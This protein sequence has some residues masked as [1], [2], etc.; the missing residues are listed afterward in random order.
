MTATQLQTAAPTPRPAPRFPYLTNWRHA[1]PG[2]LYPSSVDRWGVQRDD[3]A[4]LLSRLVSLSPEGV[5]GYTLRFDFDTA[6]MLDALPRPQ[7]VEEARRLIEVMLQ[8]V[9]A[10]HKRGSFVLRYGSGHGWHV[11]GLLD[12]R[13]VPA[14]TALDGWDLLISKLDTLDDVKRYANYCTKHT[15]KSRGAAWS[16]Q[17]DAVAERLLRDK[18]ECAAQGL[19]YS[20]LAHWFGLPDRKTWTAEAVKLQ[21]DRILAARRERRTSTHLPHVAQPSHHGDSH[22]APAMQ[23]KNA[24]KPA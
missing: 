13:A 3:G 20:K 6:A 16:W 14:L 22:E 12:S 4:G 15:R 1:H 24:S 21:R 23:A 5:A 17:R 10:E 19:S 9:P 18:A 11:H 8:A 2:K 7:R